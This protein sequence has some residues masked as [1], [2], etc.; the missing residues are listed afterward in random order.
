MRI[1]EAAKLLGVHTMTLRRWVDQ[2]L[3]RCFEVGPIGGR[4]E[5]RF[6][7]EDILTLLRER[8]G[9]EVGDEG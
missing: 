2:G 1:G 4:P 9:R 3:L 8:Q 6:A 5:R 7:R